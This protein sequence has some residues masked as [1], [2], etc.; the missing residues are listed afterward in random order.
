MVGVRLARDFHQRSR[1]SLSRRAA[2][3][4]PRAA[5]IGHTLLRLSMLLAAACASAPQDGGSP[6]GSPIGS[7]V[8]Y[9]TA[10]E[11]GEGGE[12][13]YYLRNGE[14]ETRLYFDSDPN[15]EPG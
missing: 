3:E 8:V 5:R 4:V 15:L 2:R 6:F 14:T 9:M 7:I 13:L 11:D 12:K 1:D 10:Y